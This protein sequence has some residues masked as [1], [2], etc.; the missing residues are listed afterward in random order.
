[1]AGWEIVCTVK[2]PQDEVMAFVAHHLSI[3]CARITICFDDPDDPAFPAVSRLPQVVAIRCDAAHWARW[4]NRPDRHQNR[5]SRNALRAYRLCRQPWIAHID[6]DEF[7]WPDQPG[8]GVQGSV[9][10]VSALLDSLPPEQIML[11]TEPHEAMHDPGLPDDIFTARHFR[12]PMKAALSDLRRAALGPLAQVLTEGVLSHSAGKA[13]FRA[14]IAGLVPRI[15]GGS[16]QGERL[17]GPRFDPRLKLLH[18]HAQDRGRWLAALPFRLERG[19]Y[20]YRPELHDH[21][22]AATPAEITAFYDATQTVTE[23][24]A[25]LLAATGRLVT[26]DLHLREKVAALLAAAAGTPAPTRAP[27]CD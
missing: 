24:Q 14:G 26:A 21:L 4:N 17:P 20:Q 11:R 12:A 6:V 3:G 7:L 27:T 8:S 16:L 2:A 22:G 23:E 18:F 1:M 25:A 10:P 9:Q 15:H 5:Q 19:A 13:F